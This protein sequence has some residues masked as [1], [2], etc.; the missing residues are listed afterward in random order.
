MITM[1]RADIVRLRTLRSGYAVPLVVV[2]L[3]AGITAAS[4][5]DAG[6][7][8]MTTATQLRE[9][10]TASAGILVAVTLALFAAMRV[11]SEYRY[12]TMTQRQL[13]T[14]RRTTLLA[15]TLGVHGLLGL[16]VGAAALGLGLAVGLPMV[17]AEDLS[18]DMTPQIAA[19]VL[20]AVVAFS[21]I[22]VCCGVIFRSQSA[23][24]LVIVG[25]FFVEKVVGLFIGDAASYLPYSLLTPLL[26]LEGATIS[27]GPAAAA[28][29]VTTAV[30]VA[31]AA[32]L[33]AR[34][35][36]TA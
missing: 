23:A 16:V 22:G 32:F 8:G 34:R 28:L 30:L 11:G 10:L 21:L 33:F 17:A 31:L 15:A 25:T 13:A 36:V 20:F 4:M 6:G 12:G 9:P 14:P 2:A 1:L 27:Q 5:T 26:R 19:A 24:V 7:E 3:V 35:D 18:M 29:A